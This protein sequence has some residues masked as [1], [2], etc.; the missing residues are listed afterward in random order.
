MPSFI[1]QVVIVVLTLLALGAT[2]PLEKRNP[3]TIH[4]TINPNYVKNGP[5][6]YAK[7]LTKYGA[8]P[9]TTNQF[10]AGAGASVPAT[11]EPY[12]VQ[13]LSPVTIGNQKFKLV[14]DTGSADL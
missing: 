11:P 9:R 13:Y 12:D 5:A 7:A 4:Q 3:V 1:K 14:F 10:F 8:L 6:A 2:S